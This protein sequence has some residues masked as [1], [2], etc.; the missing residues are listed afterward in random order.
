M[1]ET[2]GQKAMRTK[3]LVGSYSRCEWARPPRELQ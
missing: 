3:E 1:D 2:V